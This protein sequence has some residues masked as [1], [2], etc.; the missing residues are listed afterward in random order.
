MHKCE[1]VVNVIF[2]AVVRATK[3]EDQGKEEG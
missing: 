3:T 2:Q 1:S